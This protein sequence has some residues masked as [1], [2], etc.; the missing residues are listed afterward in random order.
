[1]LEMIAVVITITIVLAIKLVREDIAYT[2]R[3]CD[4]HSDTTH[5]VY[6]VAPRTILLTVCDT[7]MRSK[8][9]CSR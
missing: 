2:K 5:S 3:V 8:C 4:T 7:C 6:M 9:V 1:M